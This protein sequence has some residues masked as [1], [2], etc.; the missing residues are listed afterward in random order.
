MNIFKLLLATLV[1]SMT[2]CYG[3]Y[4]DPMPATNPYAYYNGGPSYIYR[5]RG[6]EHQPA[7]VGPRPVYR[8]RENRTYSHWYHR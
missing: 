3:Y 4:N 2:G 8:Y 6:W 1:L 5:Y 7:Y